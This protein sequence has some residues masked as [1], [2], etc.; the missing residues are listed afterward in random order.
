MKRTLFL[1]RD[2]VLNVECG[3][4]TRPEKLRLIPGVAQAVA[5]LKS[6]GWQLF[7]YTNQAAVGRGL[8]S[9]GE[10]ELVHAELNRLIEADGGGLDGIYFCPHSPDNHCEC[11]KPK[12]GLLLQAEKE[13]VLDLSA[14]Y[15]IGDTLRDLQA[16]KA[17]GCRT[18]LALSGHTSI[19]DP[20]QFLDCPPDFVVPDLSAFA[21]YLLSL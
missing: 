1:D 9:L 4:I 12:S 6:A 2:G 10:L 14:C 20:N 16:G 15:A 8:M 3:V 5:R 11:R 21:S 13:Y 18:A 19:Y 7:V 17:V